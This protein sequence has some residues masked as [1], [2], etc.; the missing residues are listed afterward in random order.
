MASPG[1]Y[2]LTFL[3]YPESLASTHLV[4]ELQE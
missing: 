4:E 2:N 3:S 1:I